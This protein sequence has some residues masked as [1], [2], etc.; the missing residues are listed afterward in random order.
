VQVYGARVLRRFPGAPEQFTARLRGSQLTAARRRGKF[1]W[2]E[3]DEGEQALAVHL[4]MSGQLVL[5]PRQAPTE[6]HLRLRIEF[7]DHGPALRFVDQRTF[8]W[9]SLEDVVPGADGRPV[10]AA[11]AN[12]AP[13]MFEAGFNDLAVA[14]RM[15]RSSRAVKAALLDQSVVS[16][17]GN[18]YADEAL[19]RAKRHW[20]TPCDRMSVGQIRHLLAQA[21]EVMAEALDAGGTSF[22]SLYVN[23][24]GESGYFSRDLNVYGRQGLPCPRCGRAIVREAFANRSSYRCPRCQRSPRRAQ[25]HI[26]RREGASPRRLA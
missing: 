7:E 19:W 15:R 17:I 2:F 22:D 6:A 21:G 12:I 5:P 1:L 23:V 4:G 24:N 20:A 10:A 13:D 18:I 11:A 9:V 3:I 26:T 25:P 8:G 14:R 16:G